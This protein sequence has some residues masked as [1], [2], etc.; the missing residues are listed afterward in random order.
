M[1]HAFVSRCASIGVAALLLLAPLEVRA[2]SD[3]ESALA[4]ALYRQARELMAQG[5]YAE[6]CPK[7]AE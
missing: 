6:A 2:Q 1:A 3:T 7:L 4:E 5:K